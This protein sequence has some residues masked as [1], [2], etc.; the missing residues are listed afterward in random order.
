MKQVIIVRHAKSVPYGYDDDFNR[1]L[2]GR[3][4]EDAKKISKKLYKSGIV[5]DLVIA[6]PATRTMHTATIYC[7]NLGID[8]T[9]IRQEDELYE[10]L[11]THQFVELLHELPKEVQTVFI[12]G[13]N[14]AVHS[15]VYNLVNGFLSDMPT[16][17]T[18]AIDF[19]VDRW[20]DVSARRGKIAFQITPKSV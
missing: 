4:I 8:A 9:S 5:P 2:T 12:F 3:G 20:Q 14:P 19:E 11:T 6:S 18:V 7:Q 15:L 16:C 17:A 13:H 10:G 1:D